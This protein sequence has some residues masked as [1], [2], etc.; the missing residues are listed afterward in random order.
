MKAFIAAG[1]VTAQGKKLADA[2]VATWNAYLAQGI[3]PIMDALEKQY[4]DEYYSVLEG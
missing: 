2:V 3:K 4:T 1:T